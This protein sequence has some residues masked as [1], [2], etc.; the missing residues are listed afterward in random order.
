MLGQ[1]ALTLPDHTRA[2][3]GDLAAAQ[4]QL[5]D[6]P[7]RAQRMIEIAVSISAAPDW[8][9]LWHREGDPGILA[10]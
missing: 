6:D 2:A 8:G 3:G 10:P 7:H 1:Q 9:G 5:L 4:Y